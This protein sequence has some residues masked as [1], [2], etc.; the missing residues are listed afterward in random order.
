MEGQPQ[1]QPSVSTM[2]NDVNVPPS[3][4]LIQSPEQQAMTARRLKPHSRS[5]MAIDKASTKLE[6]LT[7][8]QSKKNRPTRW[9]FGIRSRNSP[10]EAM[11][12]LYRALLAMGAEWE[13]PE[14]RKPMGEPRPH[15]GSRS[16][17]GSSHGSHEGGYY[18]EDGHHWSDEEGDVDRNHHQERLRVTNGVNGASNVN[19]ASD[20][21]G[22]SDVSMDR[23]RARDRPPAYGTHN[24]FGYE[25]P[26]DPWVIN[27]RYRKGGLYPPGVTAGSSAHSSRVDLTAVE[28]ELARLRRQGEGEGDGN[29]SV[30]DNASYSG[31]PSAAAAHAAEPSQASP[32]ESLFVYLTIQLYSI[33]KEFFLVDF[34][35][36]GY[37]RI[38]REVRREVR[39][40]NG[41]W[42][43][44]G[45][46]DEIEAGKLVRE[47]E[48]FEGLGRASAEKLATSP[49]PFLDVVSKL[50][51]Q[52]AETKPKE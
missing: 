1:P 26:V 7:P 18:D 23:G 10:S 41:E 45:E 15:S 22:A 34:K 32:D 28:E 16:S 17:S 39:E 4:S 30:P 29:A 9:Q 31:P 48:V 47:R 44:I 42:K 36:A 35:S 46:K 25:V 19:G 13:V 24:D 8:I 27:A 2:P 11:L 20:L 51:A 37:E 38:R 33:E 3:D 50:V 5:T 43:R 49:F 40:E 21:N 14:I 52:L 6:K 12:A